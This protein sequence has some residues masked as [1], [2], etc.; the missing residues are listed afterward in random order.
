MSVRKRL[1]LISGYLLFLA[2]LLEALARLAFLIPPVSG[3][4]WSDEDYSWRRSWVLRH[5]N[6]KEVNYSFDAYDPSKGW[7]SK[8]NLRNAKVFGNKLLNTN[9]EGFRGERDV[10]FIKSREK[11]RILILGDSF[12]FGDEVSDNETYSYYLQD[13]LP[14]TEVINLGVH[15]YGHDQML[16]LLEEQGIRWAP[17]IVILG[18]IPEDM[19]RN[20]LAFRDFAKPCFVLR[21]G[22]LTLTN[23]PVPRPEDIL[24]W[25]WA[26][27]RIFDM[28]AI[29]RFSV[30]RLSGV[31]I[32]DS[33]TITTAILS[34]MV[35]AIDS[36]QAIPVFAYLPGKGEISLMP[37][38]AQEAY[39]F[40]V[41]REI[42]KARCFSTRPFFAQKLAKG[43]TFKSKGHWGPEGHLTIAESLE[44]YLVDELHVVSRS[45]RGTG[46]QR[47]MP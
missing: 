35:K 46:S 44:H 41:C 26:R 10:P 27:P 25:D 30:R 23:T 24:R 36:V 9:A 37:T 45:S 20:L 11:P 12:T 14:H 18:F 38:T 1:A 2:F 13:M 43:E 5:G 8:P 28:F 32:R 21:N 4:L 19:S 39:M 29:V 47:P 16:I 42:G 6:G 7:R 17:D 31:R 34:E 40:S 33:E 22:T 3:R 15:G